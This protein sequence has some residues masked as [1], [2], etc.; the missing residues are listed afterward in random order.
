MVETCNKS[1][2]NNTLS[3]ITTMKSINIKTKLDFDT[4]VTLLEKG[5]SGG[6]DD[7]NFTFNTIGGKQLD[8]PIVVPQEVMSLYNLHIATKGLLTKKL[9]ELK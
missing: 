6:G 5:Y 8:E 2:R 9:K 7:D 1:N 3:K 4:F